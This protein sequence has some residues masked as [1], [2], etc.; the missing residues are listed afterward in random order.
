MR[1]RRSKA[2]CAPERLAEYSTIYTMFPVFSLVLDK[3]VKSEVAMLYP[4]LYKDLLKMGCLGWLA[5]E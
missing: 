2:G 1:R 5:G 3:D 4:E